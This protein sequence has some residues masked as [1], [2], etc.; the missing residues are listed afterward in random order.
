MTP[1]ANALACLLALACARFL[2]RPKI[3]LLKES[4]TIL[5]F[6]LV[7]CFYTYMACDMDLMQTEFYPFRMMALFLCFSTTELPHKRRR[8]LVLAQTA[9]LWIE[10]FG[11]I[12]L[13][14]RGLE[15]PWIRIAAIAGVAFGSSFL[16][17]INREMEF[18]LMVF[19]IA[20]WAFF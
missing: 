10:F 18:C 1:L 9:W 16:S 3:S 7:S 12:S 17:R 15:M 5:A 19:W 6:A 4:L 13:F 11:G 8:F 2:W 14:Y 20:I